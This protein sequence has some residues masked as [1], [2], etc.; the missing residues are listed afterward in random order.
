MA[1]I[2][3]RE[4]EE[5]TVAVRRRGGKKQEVMLVEEFAE[6]LLHEI[7]TRALPA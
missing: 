5:G 4:V 6:K 3:G 1:V 2:G 7:S